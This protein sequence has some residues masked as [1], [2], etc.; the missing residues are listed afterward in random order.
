M[1]RGKGCAAPSRV[2]A[3]ET[4]LGRS[5]LARME[6]KMPPM[7]EV[8]PEARFPLLTEQAREEIAALAARQR[9]ANGILIKAVT[10]VGGQVEDRMKLLPQK[11]RQQVDE[12]ARAAL[13]QSYDLASKSRTGIGG[14]LSGDRFHRVLGTVAGAFGGLGGLPTALVELPVTTTLIFRAVHHVAL[15][16]GELPEAEETRLQCL[17]VFGAGG[18]LEDDDGVNTAFVGARLALSG[19]TL[20]GLIAQVAPKLAAVLSQKLA[21]QAVPILGAAAGAGTNYIFVDYYVEMAH[22]HFGLRRLSRTFGEQQVTDAFHAAFATR[23]VHSDV[24]D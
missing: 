7:I 22:V 15:A 2:I 12:A 20:N 8:N 19:A 24:V 5:H 1:M 4:D 11:A 23:R 16:H 6:D 18:P 10:Y 17:A 13:R 9:D 14:Q 21:T 3:I